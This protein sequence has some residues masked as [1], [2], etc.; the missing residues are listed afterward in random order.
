MLRSARLSDTE[1]RFQSSLA[2]KVAGGAAAAAHVTISNNPLVSANDGAQNPSRKID[3][4][5]ARS[6]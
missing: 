6:R 3:L 1:T 2:R 5:T 4:K